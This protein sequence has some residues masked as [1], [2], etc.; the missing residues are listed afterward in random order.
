M[1]TALQLYL[2]V[3]KNDHVYLLVFFFPVFC[4]SLIY[5][6]FGVLLVIFDT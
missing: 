1:L 2:H 6:G 3:Y 4:K 5:C